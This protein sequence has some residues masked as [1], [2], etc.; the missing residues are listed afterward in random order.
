MMNLHTMEREVL[1]EIFN[2]LQKERGKE[3]VR[4]LL[5]SY[6]DGLRDLGY[7]RLAARAE[8]AQK[9]RTCAKNG[10][11][12]VVESGMDCDCLK[13]VHSYL[14]AAVPFAVERWIDE[15]Y[16]AAEGPLCVG[17]E[18]PDKLPENESRDLAL[19]AF[20]DGHPHVVYC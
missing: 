12:G 20:E 19:E 15:S 9:I 11:V 13:Y 4:D 10:E 18:H 1:Q 16:E 5:R 7:D 14:L 8:L 2:Y 6:R 3:H 17:V